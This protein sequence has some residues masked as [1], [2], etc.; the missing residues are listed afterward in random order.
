MVT[1]L[2]RLCS[3]AMVLVALATVASCGPSDTYK[4]NLSELPAIALEPKHDKPFELRE[5]L[6]MWHM[7]A[8]DIRCFEAEAL[9]NPELHVYGWTA[10]ELDAYAASCGIEIADLWIEVARYN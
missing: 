1:A 4:Q 8:E 5:T 9:A 10:D 2:A 3:D 6:Q 7:K